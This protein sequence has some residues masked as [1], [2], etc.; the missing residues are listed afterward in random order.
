M[1][2]H[3]GM[4]LIR[5]FFSILDKVIYGLISII[6]DI[7]LELSSTSIISSGAIEDLY[8]RAYTI[9]GIFMLFK[10]TF[11][12]VN[13]II[14]PE[15]FTDKA[16]GVQNLAKN[17]IIVLVLIVITPFAFSKLY[18][19]QD[20]IINDNLIPRFIMGISD[21]N[22]D[23]LNNDFQMDSAC[24]SF[25]GKAKNGNFIALA[26]FRPFFQLEDGVSIPPGYCSTSADLNINSYLN[27]NIYKATSGGIY[28]VDYGFFM[29][30]IVGIVIVLILGSFC[31]DIAVRTIKLAFLQM[32]AP[33]PIMSYI[34]PASGKNGMFSKWLK[35]I[36]STWA[37]LFIRLFALFFAVYMVDIISKSDIV[38]NL[39]HP[40]WTTLFLVIGAL[41]FAKQ[42]PKLIEELIPGLKLGGLQLNPFKK[43]ANDAFGGKQLLG[44]GAA[45][46]GLGAGAISSIG[47]HVKDKNDLRKQTNRYNTA[48]KRREYL[49]SRYNDTGDAR[50]QHR[51]DLAK[52]YE[53]AAEEKLNKLQ[54]KLTS[55]FSFNHP[56]IGT[57][58]QS[59][60]GAKLAYEQGKGGHLK[61]KDI[62]QKSSTARDYKD[63]HSIKD[64]IVEQAT[65]FFGIK[66]ESGT[67]SKLKEELKQQQNLLSNIEQNLRMMNNSFADAYSKVGAEEMSKMLTYDN[68]TGLYSFDSGYDVTR[69]PV[70]IKDID[71]IKI[72]LK[73]IANSTAD[74]VATEKKIASTQ[75]Q[76]ELQ[77]PKAPSPK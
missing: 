75:K 30:T 57:F 39:K 77:Y 70:P 40:V 1:E 51:A 21:T 29:S 53:D 74:K 58:S 2:K 42:L 19:V 17:V 27:S 55:K 48:K 45:A 67:T 59:F 61:L 25:S 71:N 31:L 37:S 66:N 23:G 56:I 52:G 5:S 44:A 4:S 33:V 7:I 62:G 47:A 9:L 28:S 26:A 3:W 20:A 49:E 46:I 12:F 8:S 76:M 64:R 63:T 60:S 18:E 65:D 11:S 10:L 22:E 34:D 6:Y 16:K 38:T 32:I 24:G 69:S 41:I 72:L 73:Q 13:Y 14:N 36:G 43:I 35:Q 68:K 50:Y 54:E 15:S